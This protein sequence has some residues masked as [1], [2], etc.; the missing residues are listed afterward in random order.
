MKLIKERN[1]LENF[2]KEQCCEK[3][4]FDNKKCKEFSF[5]KDQTMF[6]NVIKIICRFARLGT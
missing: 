4:C 2:V 1:L 5:V 3:K 6:R